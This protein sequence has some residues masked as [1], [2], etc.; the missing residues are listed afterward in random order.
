M[1]AWFNEVDRDKGGMR[2]GVMASAFQRLSTIGLL[3]SGSGAEQATDKNIQS[4][5]KR[6]ELDL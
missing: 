2:C 4:A 5:E 1:V 3:I 6:A